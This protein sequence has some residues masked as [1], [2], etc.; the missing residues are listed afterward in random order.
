MS[1]KPIMLDIDAEIALLNK[2]IEEIQTELKALKSIRERKVGVTEKHKTHVIP[3]NGGNPKFI[4]KGTISGR[5]AAIQF[6][7]RV[8]EPQSAAEIHRRS[9]ELGAEVTYGSMHAILS[10]AAKKG[11]I[12]VKTSQ[13]GYFGLKKWD[14]L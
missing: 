14:H 10:E 11:K 3:S 9:T 1:T 4:S 12:I 8:G 7:Q 13:R 2:K 6:L 5:T